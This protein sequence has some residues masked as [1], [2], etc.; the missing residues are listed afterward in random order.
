MPFFVPGCNYPR[1]LLIIAISQN[2]I[3]LML[4]SDF[5][6]NAYMKRKPPQPQQEQHEQEQKQEEDQPKA[7]SS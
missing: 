2:F 1:V 6:Y 7:K 4:F 5:Y 3:M